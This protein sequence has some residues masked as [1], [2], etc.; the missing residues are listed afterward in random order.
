MHS[1]EDRIRAVELYYRYGKK[2]SVVVMELGYPSTKQP[3]IT[4]EMVEKI[5]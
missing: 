5:A 3:E 2:A 4:P 1:Y